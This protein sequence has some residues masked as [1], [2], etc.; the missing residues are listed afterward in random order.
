MQLRGNW[1]YPTTVRFGAGRVAE[2]PEAL[3]LAGIKRPLFVTDPMLAK[4]PM[5]A[6]AMD[7]LASAGVPAKLFSDMQPNPVEANIKAGVAAYKAG[8]HD[9]VI[10]FG[11]GS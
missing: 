8:G 6:K 1:N 10:A 4:M 2:L 11:G 7:M 3:R 5:T 9:G